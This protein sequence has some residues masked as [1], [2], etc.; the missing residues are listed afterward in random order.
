MTPWGLV[1]KGNPF[2]GTGFKPVMLQVGK[3]EL[4]VGWVCSFENQLAGKQQIF[5]YVAGNEE[6]DSFRSREFSLNFL[7]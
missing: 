5:S 7:E 3:G 6:D 1:F 2:C 4:K